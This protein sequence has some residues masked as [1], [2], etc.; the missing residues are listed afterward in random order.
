M[1]S[2][3]RVQPEFISR[4]EGERLLDEKARKFLGMSGPEFR[5]KFRSGEITYADHPD[6]IRVSFLISLGLE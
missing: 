1:A 5:R 3:P 4:E 6:V 2:A